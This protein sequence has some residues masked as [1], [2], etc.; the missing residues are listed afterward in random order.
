MRSS[1]KVG[2]LTGGWLGGLFLFTTTVLV[3]FYISSII[4]ANFDYNLS[5]DFMSQ[6]K[7]EY[8]AKSENEFSTPLM[9]VS[10]LSAKILVSGKMAPIKISSIQEPF[11]DVSKNLLSFFI[12]NEEDTSPYLLLSPTPYAKSYI[13]IVNQL[14]DGV[15]KNWRSPQ[16][17]NLKINGVNRHPYFRIDLPTNDELDSVT[18]AEAF[19]SKDFKSMTSK[20]RRVIETSNIEKKEK[21]LS[22]MLVYY[23]KDADGNTSISHFLPADLREFYE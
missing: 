8:F 17:V 21:W 13:E 19:E 2:K 3:G 12:T 6:R 10:E 11:S 14:S 9:D 16:L 22:E 23:V 18:L 4:P 5:L 7:L 15:V 1:F 20:W